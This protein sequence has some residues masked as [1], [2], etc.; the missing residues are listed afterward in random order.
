MTVVIKVYMCTGMLP[1]VF[2]RSVRKPGKVEFSWTVDEA[3]AELGI[4]GTY[5][6][7]LAFAKNILLRHPFVRQVELPEPR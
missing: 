7:A 1:D 5:E 3:T 2:I 4:A 6:E